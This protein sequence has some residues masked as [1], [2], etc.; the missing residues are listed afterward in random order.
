MGDM[1]VTA[2][3]RKNLLQLE[4]LTRDELIELIDLAQTHLDVVKRKEPALKTLDG[5]LVANLFFEDS[6]RTRCSFAI[7]ARRLGAE[8]VDL[9]TTGSSVSKGETIVDTAH[10]VEAMGVDAIVMRAKPSGAAHL[11]AQSVQA[12]VINAGDGRHEHPTQGLLDLLTMRQHLGDM[13]TRTVVI[14]GDIANSR[15]ARSN[16]HALTTIGAHVRLIG[17]PTLV[18]KSFE[19]IA[20]GPGSVIV[21]HDFD[22][23]LE[24]ADVVM[25]LRVQLERQAGGNIPEDYRELYGLSK[26]RASRLK[27]ETIVMHPG[28]MNRG[29]E[30]DSEVAD[31]ASR[32]VILQQ[33]TNGVAVRMAVLEMLIPSS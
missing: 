6:T 13:S 9:S 5:K 1:L 18:S 21:D 33:V 20:Q 3:D 7:A 2:W 19:S 15:V 12:P 16:V 28:P 26:K 31:D 11:V 23:A 29:L 30:I 17:P 24:D 22:V 25:M 14:V 32:S 8:V 27:P 4:G 10:T